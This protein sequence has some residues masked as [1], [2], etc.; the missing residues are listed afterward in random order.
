MDIQ[1]AQM[2]RFLEQLYQMSSGDTASEVSMYDI[3]DALGLD[4]S[5]AGAMAEDLIID[6]FAELKSLAGAISVT[7]EGLRALDMA[8]GGA[9][10]EQSPGEIILGKSEVLDAG[11]AAAVEA[12]IEEVKSVIS[13]GQND[14]DDLEEMVIDIKTLTT[15][16]L[17]RR[18]K[19]AVVRPLLS[20]LSRLLEGQP[21]SAQL[22][23][24]IR[25]MAD[26]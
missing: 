25:R 22:A 2:K 1:D 15:Q 24:R 3:G 13:A 14:Y 10:E 8:P 23:G 17:S 4:K 12:L 18:P 26:A 11:A 20:S 16:L 19:T 5:E 7:M 6:G 9:D 21:E